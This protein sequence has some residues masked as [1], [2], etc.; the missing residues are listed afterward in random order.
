[1]LKNNATGKTFYTTN[2][3]FLKLV[4]LK[5]EQTPTT[6]YPLFSTCFTNVR[7][8]SS[9]QSDYFILTDLITAKLIPNSVTIVCLFYTTI[10]TAYTPTVEC[11]D[12]AHIATIIKRRIA[13][14]APIPH[15]TGNYLHYSF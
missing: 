14:T 3:S 12:N 2:S 10:N 4:E 11:E 7:L 6:R 15:G 9:S 13:G 8:Q 1:M 5:D